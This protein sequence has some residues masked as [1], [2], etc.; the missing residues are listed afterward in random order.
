MQITDT[1]AESALNHQCLFSFLQCY[2]FCLHFNWK[3]SGRF[4][5]SAVATSEWAMPSS[6]CNTFFHTKDSRKF[7]AVEYIRDKNA[8]LLVCLKVDVSMNFQIGK[9]VNLTSCL[10]TVQECI[11]NLSWKSNILCLKS[12]YC[13]KK[14]YLYKKAISFKVSFDICDNLHAWKWLHF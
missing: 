11:T 10:D 14:K 4:R 13:Y 3:A 2:C 5:D 8:C 1:Y 9:K 7:V 6:G 12:C